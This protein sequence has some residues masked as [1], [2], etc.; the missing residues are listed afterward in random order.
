MTIGKKLMIGFSAMA[1][2]TLVLSYASL[3]AIG[4]IGGSLETVVHRDAKR[5]ELVGGITTDLAKLRTAQRG[6]I[7]YSQA[8]DRARIDTNKQ[9][10]ATVKT[11]LTDKLASLLP[12]LVTEEGKAAATGIAAALVKYVSAYEEI[13]KSCD[14]GN[15]AGALRS[16][17]P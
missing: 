12:L 7:M 1:V 10:F 2:L 5:L 17:V 9:M 4:K 13:V 11:D 8:K 6:V 3:S 14:A 16:A 15:A